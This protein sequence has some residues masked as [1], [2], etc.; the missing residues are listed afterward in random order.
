MTKTTNNGEIRSNTSSNDDY[1]NQRPLPKSKTELNPFL[2]TLISV[3]PARL[4]KLGNI[5]SSTAINFNNEELILST[6]IGIFTGV[7]CTMKLILHG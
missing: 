5:Y 2:D 4:N 6:T 7:S 1:P 3:S